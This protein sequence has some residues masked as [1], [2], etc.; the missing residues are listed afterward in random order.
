MIIENLN[1]SEE[2]RILLQSAERLLTEAYSF[3]RRRTYIAAPLRHS[4]DVWRAFVDMGWTAMPFRT[5]DGGLGLGLSD[6]CRL[7]EIMGRHL[8]IEPYGSTVIL[9]GC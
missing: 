9:S 7:A 1:A 5:D 6:M 3:D 2:Q 4:P 8:V